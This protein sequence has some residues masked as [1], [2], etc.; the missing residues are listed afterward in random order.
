MAANNNL[1]V[2]NGKRILLAILILSLLA[3]YASADTTG[4]YRSLT[5]KGPLGLLVPLGIESIPG[6]TAAQVLWFYNLISI[7]ILF[8][9]GATASERNLRHFAILLPLMAALVVFFGWLQ[10]PNPVTTWSII[11]GAGFLGGLIYMKE[12]LRENWG[13]GGPGSTL[14]NI[15][16]FLI[17]FQCIV[18]VVNSPTVGLFQNNVAPTPAEYQSID[19]KAQVN[20]LTN[21][22]GVMQDLL[23][24]GSLFVTMAIG[25]VKAFILIVQAILLFSSTVVQAYPVFADSPLVVM[26]LTVFQLGEWV[27]FAKLAYDMYYVKNIFGVE[28]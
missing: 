18:G 6:I 2:M 26:F 12:T 23:S 3:G 13:I 8:I 7:G 1:Y 25:A 14:I 10:T 5:C 28:F 24:F 20:S 11:L 22:G 19:L 27:L 17:I 4:A 15:A 21:T 9:I 16:V